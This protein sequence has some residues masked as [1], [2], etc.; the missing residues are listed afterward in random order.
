[1]TDDNLQQNTEAD[2]GSCDEESIIETKPKK[3]L[4]TILLEFV[5]FNLGGL[6]VS[7]IE[8]VVYTCLL[9]VGL[10]YQISFT[11]GNIVK[12]ILQFILNQKVVFK[13]EKTDNKK[14][15]RKLLLFRIL[16]QAA[17]SVFML[18][19]KAVMVW[20]VVE[21]LK[22]GENP[23]YFVV[24]ILETPVSFFLDRNWT[25]RK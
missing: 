24:M 25:F 17:K 5:K 1:M 15:N 9:W 8:Y 19:F 23:A 4:L 13:V 3:K 12:I 2:N 7:A 16:R 18:A 14:E 10:A 6:V 22:V 11:S 21:K 20:L